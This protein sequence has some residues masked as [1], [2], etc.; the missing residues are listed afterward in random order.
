MDPGDSKVLA[1]R[2]GRPREPSFA[3]PCG[4]RQ[5]WLPRGLPLPSAQPPT[6]KPSFSPSQIWGCLPKGQW[7]R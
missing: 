1:S 6:G 4:W 2:E 3:C 7:E 5:A